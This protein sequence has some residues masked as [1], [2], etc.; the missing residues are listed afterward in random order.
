MFVESPF[1]DPAVLVGGFQ[2]ES[3]I[4][5]SKTFDNTFLT[6][7]GGREMKTFRKVKFRV[8]TF[9]SFFIFIV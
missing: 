2:L 8:K 3:L 4:R 6:Y 1:V 9:F 7:I 5:L